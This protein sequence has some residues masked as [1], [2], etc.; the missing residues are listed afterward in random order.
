MFGVNAAFSAQSASLIVQWP[1]RGANNMDFLK[2]EVGDLKKSAARR[3]GE[4]L[5][6]CVVYLWIN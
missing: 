1:T 6:Y 3:L 4:C 5:C 2:T